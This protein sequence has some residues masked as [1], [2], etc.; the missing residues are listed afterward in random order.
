MKENKATMT[1]EE[2]LNDDAESSKIRQLTHQSIEHLT[3]VVTAHFGETDNGKEILDDLADLFFRITG[4]FSGTVLPPT[5]HGVKLEVPGGIHKQ[6]IMESKET[7][8]Q[9]G[10]QKFIDRVENDF[11]YKS[12]TEYPYCVDMW[13]E[14]KELFLNFNT[15]TGTLIDKF[16]YS[17]H[18]RED[19]Y[20]RTPFRIADVL[21]QSDEYKAYKLFVREAERWCNAAIA[22]DSHDYIRNVD[23]LQLPNYDNTDAE[24]K[25]ALPYIT[26]ICQQFSVHLAEILPH[27]R[28]LSVAMT[29]MQ[30][31][32]GW[33]IDIFTQVYVEEHHNQYLESV[34]LNKDDNNE[35]QKEESV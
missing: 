28:S 16:T 27:G 2:V 6:T 4:L 13:N 19:N 3:A 1:L 29:S 14:V 26:T 12:P 30:N 35:P 20:D 9:R 15:L 21:R 8:I 5:R 11:T 10:R 18:L 33:L 22:N 23:N 7:E 17:K 31:V 24:I 25:Y 32:R 34:D